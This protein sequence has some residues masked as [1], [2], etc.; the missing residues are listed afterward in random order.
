MMLQELSKLGEANLVSYL[1]RWKE[2]KEG[3]TWW[4]QVPV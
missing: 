2:L 3:S 1:R 4:A